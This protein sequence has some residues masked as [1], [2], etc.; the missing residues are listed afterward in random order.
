M[1]RENPNAAEHFSHDKSF[2]DSSRLLLLATR[3]DTREITYTTNEHT[4]ISYI[5]KMCDLYMFLSIPNPLKRFFLRLG[6]ADTN[7]YQLNAIAWLHI[8]FVLI[9]LVWENTEQ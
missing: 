4:D 2:G 7:L 1:C 5:Q 3:T 9:T 6:S 8:K